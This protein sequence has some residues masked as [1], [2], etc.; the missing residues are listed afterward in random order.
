MRRNSGSAESAE[1]LEELAAR[2]SLFR[3]RLLP[4]ATIPPARDDQL[5]RETRA[6]A[7]SASQS[8]WARVQRLPR[9]HRRAH[10]LATHWEHAATMA[11]WHRREVFRRA[12]ELGFGLITRLATKNFV[13]AQ[14]LVASCTLAVSSPPTRSTPPARSWANTPPC[15][16]RPVPPPPTPAHH[17]NPGQTKSRNART[18]GARSPIRPSCGGA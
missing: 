5:A 12:E 14:F 8:F 13:R 1:L 17:T 7:R 10:S 15:T 9:T 16:P 3:D 2:T 6:A 18:S 11:Y 4:M